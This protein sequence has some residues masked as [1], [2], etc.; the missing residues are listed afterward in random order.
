MSLRNIL[1]ENNY[2][3]NL[4]VRSINVEQGNDIE[5]DTIKV[6]TIKEL[7]VLNGVKFPNTIKCDALEDFG[8]GLHVGIKRMVTREPLQEFNLYNSQITSSN[9]AQKLVNYTVI[10]NGDS[11]SGYLNT[12]DIVA[13]TF[14]VQESGFYATT[15]NVTWNSVNTAVNETFYFKCKNTV[16]GPQRNGVELLVVPQAYTGVGDAPATSGAIITYLVAGDVLEIEHYRQGGASAAVW[17][18]QFGVYRL[19]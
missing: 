16:G 6:N 1:V 3:A 10:N 12:A 2:A 5:T 7:T 19:K 11:A 17:D 13:G 8:A 18:V 9:V 14:T 4:D 15:M